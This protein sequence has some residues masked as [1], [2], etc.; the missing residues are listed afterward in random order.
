MD[1]N[2]ETG[3]ATLVAM[4]AMVLLA[5]FGAA[6]VLSTSAETRIAA[7][8]Q[9]A[10]GASYAADAALEWGIGELAGVADLSALLD[11][12]ARSAFVDGSPDG[13]RRLDDG[14]FVSLNEIVS[15]ANCGR[16]TACTHAQMDAVTV[17]RPWG[18]N[19]P[20][21]RLFAYGFLRD[22]ARGVVAR[23]P[24]YVVLLVADD[25]AETDD[26]PLTDGGGVDNPG[27]GAILVRGEAFGEAGSHGAV[28][29]TVVRRAGV[30]SRPV[31]HVVS[32]RERS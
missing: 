10:L 2:R 21:W 18:P 32:W 13:P 27:Q 22:L 3:L 31:L 26:D 19:N 7:N 8:F 30:Q 4:T 12:S 6:L 25:P 24:F 20:R 23:S 15:L 16:L 29:A 11:G 28:E 5:A 9:R 1:R 14:R 17:E